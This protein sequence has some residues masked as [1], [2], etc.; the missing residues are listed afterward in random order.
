MY[1]PAIAVTLYLF[2]LVLSGHFSGFFLLLGAISSLLVLFCLRR[3]DRVDRSPG[4][5][6]PAPGLFAYGAWLLWSVVRSNID[7]ARR[8]WD[9]SL[10]IDPQWRPL[11]VALTKPFGRALY[12]NSIT[13]TP[14]TLT[15][16]VHPGHFNIHCLSEAAMEELEE[17]EMERRIRRLGR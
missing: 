2:W 10:P 15:T 14:G 12:A 9:P 8:I 17:G 1:Y 11:K 4:F 7:V 13:L 6:P 16:D 5:V 3:M